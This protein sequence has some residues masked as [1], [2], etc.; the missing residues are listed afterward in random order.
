MN[1]VVLITGVSSGIGLGLAELFLEK[2]FTVYG[3]SRSAFV[4]DGLRHIVCD[5]AD[6][7]ACERTAE[8]I[9]SEAGGVDILIN[10]A[11]FGISGPIENTCEDFAKKLIDV[12]FFGPFHMIRAFLPS[13]RERKGRIVNISSVASRFS[14]PFQAFYSASKSAL[15]SL[16]SALRAE[17]RPYGVKVISILPGNTRTGFTKNRMKQDDGIYSER[18]ERSTGKME[19][20]EQ[21]SMDGAEVAKIIFKTV[22]KRR[23]PAVK[24]IGLSYKFLVLMARFLPTRTIEWL[25]FK[26]YG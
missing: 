17:I 9:L 15:D 16:S 4:L 3:V 13:L 23:P 5:V 7:A 25:I 11:G 18:S 26:L 8:M 20:D 1:K 10:N 22:M 2:G 21:N 19:K 12:N 24:T 6:P 14:I